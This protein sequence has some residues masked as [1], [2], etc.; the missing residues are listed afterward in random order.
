MRISLHP[1]TL[2]LFSLAALAACGSQSS[3]SSTVGALSP[4]Q[5]MAVTATQGDVNA[6]K[7]KVGQ[8]SNVFTVEATALDDTV[9]PQ[10]P[11]VL[12]TKNGISVT[13]KDPLRT[14]WVRVPKDADLD[15]YDKHGNVNV[16]DIS[17]NANVYT[18][19]GDVQIMVPGYAQAGVGIG[20]LSATLG[21]DA[22][23]GVLKFTDD[24]GDVVV[25]IIEK[26]KFHVHLHTDDGILFSDFG[27]TGQHAGTSETIDSDVNGG[28]SHGI[29]IE[30]K[31][32]NIRLLRL[33]P[34]A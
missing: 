12:K 30:V 19:A 26:A 2:L 17:G 25:Y 8:P 4:R 10:A 21:A 20:N 23:P 24:Q 31:K 3:F 33:T 1:R 15:I 16:T 22:W 32:G 11:V 14:L 5:T 6:F 13:A 9:N 28:G 29:D 27:L 7:P 34:Q 18:A